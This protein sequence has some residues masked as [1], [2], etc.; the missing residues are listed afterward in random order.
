MTNRKRARDLIPKDLVPREFSSREMNK[1]GN[2]I[3]WLQKQ[4]FTTPKTLKLKVANVR[5]TDKVGFK[6]NS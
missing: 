6:V 4:D 1:K 5:G 3:E 2:T